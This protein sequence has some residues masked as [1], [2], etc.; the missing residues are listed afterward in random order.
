MRL[1]NKVAVIAGDGSEID[2][3]IASRFCNEGA[4]VVLASRS[5]EGLDKIIKGI[6]NAGGTVKIIQTEIS[7]EQSMQQMVNSV[8]EEFKRVDIL[9]TNSE[10]HSIRA[11]LVDV[12]L[13][14]WNDI[15]KANLTGTMLCIREV[16]KTM[17]P[18]KQGSIV[19]IGSVAGISGAPRNGPYCIS[20]WG[21]IGLIEMLSIEAGEHN[22]RVNSV[23]STAVK[24]PD[25][26]KITTENGKKL[27]YSYEEML[28]KIMQS[29]SLK[30]YIDVEDI[31]NAALFLASDE[32]KS[33]TGHNL[34]VSCGLHYVHPNMVQ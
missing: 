16:L 14:D 29:Y 26:K 15:L 17:I 12:T 4:K 28:K 19:S 2:A 7:N 24:T 20:K 13:E 33:I 22:I 9:I 30:K 31:A 1:E 6:Q 5:I 10:V 21:I 23:S 11:N 8:V 25:F 34:V 3:A 32:S 18:N 27:G